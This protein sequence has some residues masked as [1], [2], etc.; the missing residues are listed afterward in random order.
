MT[1][2]SVVRRAR[3]LALG[4]LLGILIGVHLGVVLGIWMAGLE[5]G[6]AEARYEA[7][8]DTLIATCQVQTVERTLA[9]REEWA[10][11][12]PT[13]STGRKEADDATPAVIAGRGG[14][15]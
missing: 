5:V 9:L 7:S 10:L 14:V 15:E 8:T 12:G 3:T 6:A 4:I 2:R 1:G 13:G 11:I